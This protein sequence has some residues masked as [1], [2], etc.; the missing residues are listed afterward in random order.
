MADS[1]KVT[2]EEINK[3]MDAQREMQRADKAK[4]VEWLKGLSDDQLREE[5]M[6]GSDRQFLSLIEIEVSHRAIRKHWTLTPGF[7]AVVITM[8]FAG[9]A[10]WPVVQGWI[11]PAK[12]DVPGELAPTLQ[13]KETPKPSATPTIEASP[14]P[15]PVASSPATT[16][17]SEI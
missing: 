10:A 5:Q 15:S 1:V 11:R 8:V 14:L 13:T 17:R 2:Q 3:A 9:I 12:K 7:I 6:K 16:P 4:T